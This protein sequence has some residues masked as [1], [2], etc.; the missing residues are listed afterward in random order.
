MANAMKR[1]LSIL[2]AIFGIL[3]FSTYGFSDP[4]QDEAA[5]AIR[6]LEANDVR[7][8]EGDKILHIKKVNMG[9]PGGENW[10][11]VWSGIAICYSIN[12][13]GEVVSRYRIDPTF[14]VNFFSR[15]DIMKNIPG[16]RIGDSSCMVGDYNGDG[17]DEILNFVMGGSNW[18][19]AIYGYDSLKNDLAYFAY[20]PFDI[21]DPENGPSPMEFIKYKGMEGFKVFF[22][23]SDVA[24]GPGYIPDPNPKNRRWFFY[25]WDGGSANLWK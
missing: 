6:I 9:I 13:A 15:F 3:F 23:Q 14:D 21:I 4:V 8:A 10:V 22:S 16:T 1:N 2:C 19:I 17:Y 11:V 20:V 18:G 7:S 12:D 25:A 24:G 5:E